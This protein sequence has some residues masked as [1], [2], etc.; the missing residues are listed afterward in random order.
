MTVGFVGAITEDLP[1]LVREEDI[2]GLEVTDIVAATNEEAAEL[3]AAGADLVVMLVH[4]GAPQPDCAIMDDDPSSSFGSIITGVSG[5]V[6]A[7]V[8]GHT[9]RSYSC[10][11]PVAEWADDDARVVKTRPVV[12][13]GEYGSYLDKL[14]FTVDPE[15]GVVQGVSHATVDVAAGNYPADPEVEAIVQAAIEASEEPGSVELGTIAA[16]FKRAYNVAAT[17]NRGGE[18]TLGNFVAEVQRWATGADLGFMNPGGLRADMVGNDEG[19]YPA[20]V[21]YRQAAVVQPFANT[22]VT[23]ELTGAQIRQILEE[24]VQPAG[25]RPFFRLGVSQGFTYTYDPSA[26][27]GSRIGTMRLN[28]EKVTNKQVLTVSANSFLA[29]GTGDNFFGFAEGVNKKD[30]GQ[31]DLQAM[32]DYLGTFAT[33]KPVKVNYRQRAVGLDWRTDRVVAPGARGLRVNLSSWSFTAPGDLQ[34]STILVKMGKRT[35]GSFAVDNTLPAVE[36]PLSL[37]DE[38]GKARINVK[39]PLGPRKKIKPGLRTVR[40]VGN[41][42]GTTVKVDI[43]VKRKK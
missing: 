18:S 28:G 29:S 16:A 41:E 38:T 35:L 40:L 34:D 24:Q 30:T 27:V 43:R 32:V 39:V 23:V 26:E 20:P 31:T 2:E 17:E 11:F 15:S 1:Q 4:E 13:A 37:F 9:H 6:D 7:I 25:G 3:K 8:S 19:G 22:L 33:S 42:T 10:E 14:V 21:T 5:D 12:S 36:D